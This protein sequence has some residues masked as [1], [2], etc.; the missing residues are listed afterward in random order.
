MDDRIR[1]GPF[2]DT[3]RIWSNTLRYLPSIVQL[4]LDQS[5]RG[6]VFCNIVT[7]TM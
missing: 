7:L 2:R 5:I 4:I 1:E 3:F 6:L